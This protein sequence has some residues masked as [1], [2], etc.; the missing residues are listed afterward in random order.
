M[1][2]SHALVE[3]L[4]DITKSLENKKCALGVFIDFN[5]AFDTVDHQLLYRKLEL[6]GIR[7]IAH[8]W[9]TSY[10][11]NRSQLVSIDG[12]SS[13]IQTIKCEVPQG[14][15]L[16]P[17]LLILYVNDICN[18]SKLVKLILFADDTNMV[19]SAN[20]VEQLENIVCCELGKLQLWFSIN[21]LSLN[22]AKTNYMLFSG[23]T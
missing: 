16:G 9:I 23:R 17:K 11:D 13:D 15:I 2:T 19:C 1:S 14:S 20:D 18:V 8:N 7:G 6:Y 4:E 10:L 3:L 12:Y 21:E 5:K 22:I